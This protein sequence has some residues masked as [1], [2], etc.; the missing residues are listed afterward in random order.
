MA[1]KIDEQKRI[2]EVGD[3]NFSFILTVNAVNVLKQSYFG[4]KIS[5]EDYLKV[6]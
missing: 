2:F 1:I 4:P 3:D 6:K 5:V